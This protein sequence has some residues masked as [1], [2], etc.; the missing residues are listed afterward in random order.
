MLLRYLMLFT[1]FFLIVGSACESGDNKPE[2]LIKEPVYMDL[3][4]EVFLIR[5]QVELRDFDE[6]QEDSLYNH[7]FEQ[8]GINRQQF[9]RSHTFYQRQGEYHL[10][11]TDSIR[12]ILQNEREAILRSQQEN[13]SR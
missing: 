3:L 11:R 10:A 9:E 6:E 2:D 13:H 5:S 8:Y 12:S 4:T 7:I 1:V